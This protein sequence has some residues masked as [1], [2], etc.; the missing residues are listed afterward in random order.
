MIQLF[1]TI[2][3]QPLLNLLVFF[4]NII[5]GHD[6]GLA[7]IAITVLI[8]V[9]LHP[10][11]LKSLKSQKA[12]Q[13][14]QP[15]IN[16]LKRIY[17]DDKS[18][19]ASELMNLYRQEKINPLSS[20]LPLLIQLPFLLAIYQVFRVGVTDK[21]L[22]LIYSFVYNPGQ[23]NSLAFGFLNLSQTSWFL[24]V[25]AGLAQFF[26]AKM[27]VA[28]KP[29]VQSQASKDEAITAMMNKQMTFFMPIITV[30]IGLSLPSGLT[31]YW[32]VVTLVTLL[33][34]WFAF[35]H[36]KTTTGGSALPQITN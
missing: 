5:P 31:L 36:K 1:T 6:L 24:A 32:L 10:F 27:L 19:L 9:V 29:A 7:I 13:E 2:F 11:S 8:K 4:Y 21:N 16:E 17:K 34:Q 35:R 3:Y 25:L 26:Q 18:K 33:Q 14:I 12:L 20:C 23:L 22:S 30:V 28:K 15:K